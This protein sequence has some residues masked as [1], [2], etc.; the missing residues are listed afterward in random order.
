MLK[1][2]QNKRKY[3]IREVNSSDKRFLFNLYN[4]NIEE[5]N[6]FETNKITFSNHNKWFNKKIPGRKIY[7]II[8]KVKIGYVKINKEKNNFNISI[9]IKKKFQNKKIAKK[10]LMS[11]IYTYYKLNDL[12]TANIK[13]RNLK[14]KKFFL[15]CGFKK[16]GEKYYYKK[17]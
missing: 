17:K 8:S 12:F 4:K 10:S 14:S 16:K 9:A 11:I 13:K 6:F 5:K 1:F 2:I 15:S 3:I 7:I